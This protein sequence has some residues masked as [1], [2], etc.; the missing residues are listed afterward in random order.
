MADTEPMENVTNTE[1]PGTSRRGVIVWLTWLFGAIASAAAGAPIIGYLFAPAID[2][3]EDQWVDLGKVDSFPVGETQLVELAKNPLAG[4]LDGVTGKLAVYVRHVQAE[5]FQVFLVNCAHL[6]CPVSWFREPGL[7]MCPCHGGVYYANG[8][9]ASGPPPRG[10]YKAE[11]K[12]E[13]GVLQA[14]LGHLP[15]LQ[16]TGVQRESYV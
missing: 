14:K 4:P 2:R 9:R 15:T 3:R 16:D 13:A 1:T 11:N 7:F 10:L 6:G 12:I 8:D 5:Q